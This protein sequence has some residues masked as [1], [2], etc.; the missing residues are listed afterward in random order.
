[1]NTVDVKKIVGQ[2]P[3]MTLEQAEEIT[4]FIEEHNIVNIL[5]LGFAHGVSTCYMA[6]TLGR[7]E[8]GGTIT[9]IDLEHSK[10]R[11]PR[12]ESLLREVGELERVNIF[13][14]PTSYLWRLMK[15]L[16]EDPT[17]TY[18]LCYV[19]GAHN[20]YVDGFAF[21]LVDRLLKPGG[22]IIFD[23]MTWTYATSP[24][25]KNLEK[26]KQMPLEERTTQQITKVFDLLVRTH[27]N[28]H[29][30][31]VTKQWGYAQ[32]KIQ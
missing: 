27:P 1:M 31:K 24:S 20:W 5:E 32:K 28:Y 25:N 18:D 10:E 21:F 3:H 4:N 29:N 30:F 22:W 11:V 8:N 16:E 9:C 2:T 19:D 7:L 6:A 12:I 23:D 14:E 17:P 15:F 26:V 13:F